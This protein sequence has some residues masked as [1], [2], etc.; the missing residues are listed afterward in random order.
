MKYFQLFEQFVNKES[1]ESV[2][3]GKVVY[4][5]A[6]TD[7]HPAKSTNEKAAIRNKI[8]DSIQTNVLT[9]EE[10]NSIIAET[11]AH[12]RWS[13]RNGHYFTSTKEG[14]K[15]SNYGLKVWEKI[16]SNGMVSEGN[17][18]LLALKEA[19]EKGEKT[20]EFNGKTFKV[21]QNNMLKESVTDPDDIQDMYDDREEGTYVFKVG[22]IKQN[23]LSYKKLKRAEA[24]YYTTDDTETKLRG[25]EDE[26][27]KYII[28]EIDD[29]G[30]ALVTFKGK[31]FLFL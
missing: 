21:K 22:S 17:A 15:L 16:K 6:Y 19:R 11:G 30:E 1:D 25:Y 18:F 12:S 26:E 24:V 7:K 13:S 14:I 27:D 2:N 5:R 28:V 31:Q 23:D 29:E 9:E 10:F 8:L 4:K 20:F 3:E